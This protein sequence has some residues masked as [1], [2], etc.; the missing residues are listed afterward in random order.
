MRDPEQLE[1]YWQ[2]VNTVKKL[3]G[4]KNLAKLLDLF[5]E[6]LVIQSVY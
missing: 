1:T 4:I 6:R 2:H 5:Q 3:A